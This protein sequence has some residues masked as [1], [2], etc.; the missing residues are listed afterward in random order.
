MQHLIILTKYSH[1]KQTNSMSSLLGFNYQVSETIF[2]KITL[3][4]ILL[5]TEMGKLS[6]ANGVIEHSPVRRY[7]PL[8]V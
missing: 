7:R 6:N 5:K 8:G 1:K 2:A 4:Y 3:S